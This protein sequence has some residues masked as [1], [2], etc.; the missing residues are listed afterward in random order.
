MKLFMKC[1]KRTIKLYIS[2]SVTID[3]LCITH[4]KKYEIGKSS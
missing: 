2:E 3:K 4:F 1:R